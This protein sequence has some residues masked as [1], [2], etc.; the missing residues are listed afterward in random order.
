METIEKNIANLLLI[1]GMK[2]PEAQQIVAQMSEEMSVKSINDLTREVAI[3]ATKKMQSGFIIDV[4][5]EVAVKQLTKKGSD[6]SFY[7]AEVDVPGFGRLGGKVDRNFYD[8]FIQVTSEIVV[9]KGTALLVINYKGE[10]AVE[11]FAGSMAAME[12]F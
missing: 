4:D 12:L 1:A 7:I 6:D 8:Q 3:R 5:S 9:F 11:Q 2:K 10:F